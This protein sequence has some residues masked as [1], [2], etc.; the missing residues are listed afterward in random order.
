MM[1]IVAG[2][3]ALINVNGAVAALV[4]VTVVLAM[5]VKRAPSELLMPLAF[6]A[7]AGSC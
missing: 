1:L 2:L 3:T 7:H 4:P 6:G 5:R